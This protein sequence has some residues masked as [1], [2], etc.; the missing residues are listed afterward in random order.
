MNPDPANES[1]VSYRWLT[2]NLGLDGGA[3]GRCG[4]SWREVRES[5]RS[6]TQTIFSTQ[7]WVSDFW[8]CKTAAADSFG[9]GVTPAWDPPDEM[10]EWPALPAH[11]LERYTPGTTRPTNHAAFARLLRSAG[12][13]AEGGSDEAVLQF[14]ALDQATTQRGDAAMTQAQQVRA[15]LTTALG[16]L[17]RGVALVPQAAH[18]ELVAAARSRL[19]VPREL[20][21]AP[22]W[23]LQFAEGEIGI[24]YNCRVS[25]HG[26]YLWGGIRIGQGEEWLQHWLWLSRAIDAEGLAAALRL[27]ARLLRCRPVLDAL[28]SALDEEDPGL[29]H[30]ALAVLRR[31]L[32]SLKAMAWLEDALA[33]PWSDVRPQDLASFAFNAVK[34]DW[35]RRC[36][37]LSHRSRDAKP[38]L[39]TMKAWRSSLFAIDA[40]YA[41]S[42][43]TNTGMM[44]GLFAATPVL[45]RVHSAHYD[46]SEWCRRE[47]E[48]IGYLE[49]ACDFMSRRLV[50]DTDVEAL[51][52]MDHMVDAWRPL[53][54]IRED[55]IPEFPP[56]SQVY[57]PGPEPEWTL[58]M[59]R[60]AAALRLLQA[61]YG[62]AAVVNRL[63]EFLCSSDGPVPV[64]APTNDPEG[65]G[66]YRTI[67]RDLQRECGLTGGALPLRLPP[68]TP[69][70][71]PDDVQAF[72]DMIPDLG[73]G[74]SSLHDVLAAMEW[75]TS[76][77]PMLEE[78]SAGDMT[79]IDLRGLTREALEA[80]PRLS[81]VRG[82]AVLRAPPRPV[83]LVQLA[84]QRVDDWGLPHDRPV[85]TQHTER[86]FSWMLAEAAFSPDWP[87]AYADRCGLE[88]SPEL[89]QKCRG[90][91]RGG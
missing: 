90:T 66:A 6:T 87:D 69:P 57:V 28:L 76:L 73:E 89:L 21:A 60:A 51:A 88:M 13:A 1:A 12:D 23:G 44:W 55:G 74:N 30:V 15:W 37:A 86:Q 84:S 8:L 72:I 5:M 35:P 14:H 77:L 43:E 47:A 32:L 38:A 68:D 54:A 58:A 85:F 70:W 9:L 19:L 45:A 50:M 67:F 2:R 65:W 75:R 48:I 49:Q 82:I 56:M 81:L 10:D 78:A 59:L 34:P 64:P 62:N 53:A 79:L 63:C 33:R 31:W 42:W 7:D 22:A 3:P 41:P 39:Q 11:L 18:D 27:T 83:W 26:S 16:S 24:L 25:P 29:R 40:N 80:D 46:E 61:G 91:R 4:R 52:A 17:L 20:G 36:V 71:H